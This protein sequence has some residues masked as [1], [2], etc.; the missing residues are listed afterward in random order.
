MQAGARVRAL[1]G[2]QSPAAVGLPLAEM[3]GDPPP[4]GRGCLLRQ[5]IEREEAGIAKS[6]IRFMRRELDGGAFGRPP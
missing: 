2:W 4:G 6:K 1:P 3:L 5:R